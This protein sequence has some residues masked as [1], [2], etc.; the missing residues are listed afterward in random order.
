MVK[1]NWFFESLSGELLDFFFFIMYR[2][3]F[4]Y[5]SEQRLVMNL[6]RTPKAQS[7]EFKYFFNV[8]CHVT[9]VII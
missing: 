8:T 1:L 6:F 3:S 9:N 7:D 5:T 2:F 4:L